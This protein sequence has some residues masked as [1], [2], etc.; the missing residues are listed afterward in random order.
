[1]EIKEK[2]YF[3]LDLIK[4][5]W[6]LSRKNKKKLVL[7]FKNLLRKLRKT[8][9]LLM[10]MLRILKVF[11]ICNKVKKINKLEIRVKFTWMEKKIKRQIKLEKIKG[12]INFNFN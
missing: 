9:R 10:I 4:L 6:K 5:F 7:N 12:K 2:N 8:N 3:V 11:I 1:M